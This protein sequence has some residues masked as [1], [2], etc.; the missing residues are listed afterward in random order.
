MIK[1]INDSPVDVKW[2]QLYFV[3]LILNMQFTQVNTCAVIYYVPCLVIFETFVF[4]QNVPIN[5]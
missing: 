2:L 4:V 1:N 3:H 5:S